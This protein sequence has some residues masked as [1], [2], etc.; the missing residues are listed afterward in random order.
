MS[1]LKLMR[2]VFHVCNQQ[3]QLTVMNGWTASLYPQQ[4]LRG[5]GCT[6]P[7]RIPSQCRP[8]FTVSA[9]CRP[10]F[11]VS[12]QC[13]PVFTVSVSVV[14]QP[15]VRCSFSSRVLPKKTL[16]KAVRP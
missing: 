14:S 3:R 11:T 1:S 4:I 15:E 10:V 16:P 7:F 13:R 2:F 9:Q 5:D 12:A 8:V 6:N